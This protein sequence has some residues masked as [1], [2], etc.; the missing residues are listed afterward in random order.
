MPDEQWFVLP[1]NP[2]PWKVPPFS[3]ARK[4][5]KIFVKAGRDEGLHAYK[6]AIKEIISNAEPLEIEGDV[7]IEMWFYR[8]IG[9]YET[10]QARTARKHEADTT[11]LQKATEDALQGVLFKNDKDVVKITSFRVEQSPNAKSFIVI[12]ARQHD[13]RLPVFPP[14]VEYEI[15]NLLAD[16][17]APTPSFNFDSD[18]EIPF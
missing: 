10:H 15:S 9:A 14:E 8:N 11:N 1:V 4:G 6:Q 12:R 3:P 17:P 13:G 18:M 5:K 2:Y 16:K 7:E